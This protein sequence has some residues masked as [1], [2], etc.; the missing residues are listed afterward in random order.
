MAG[1]CWY[2]SNEPLHRRGGKQAPVIGTK[3]VVERESS[4]EG[5]M[6]IMRPRYNTNC[7]FIPLKDALYSLYIAN[8]K[9]T[10]L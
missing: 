6:I 3:S 10:I 1:K 7:F 5:G 2:P 8:L 4:W 9:D